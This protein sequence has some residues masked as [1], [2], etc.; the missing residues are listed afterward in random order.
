VEETSEVAEE[1]IEEEED[2]EAEIEIKFKFKSLK[3]LKN[4]FIK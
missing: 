3:K 2:S 1:E 4:S